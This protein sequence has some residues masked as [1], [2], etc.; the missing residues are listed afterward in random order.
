M[1]ST[2]PDTNTIVRITT[3]GTMTA[4]AVPTLD[5]TLLSIAAGADG[6]L[7]FIESGPERIGR[8]TP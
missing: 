7:W 1:W 8:L 3:G 6:N 2:D 4:F 5:N